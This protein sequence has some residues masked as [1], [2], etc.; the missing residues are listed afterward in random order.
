MHPLCNTGFGFF[1]DNPR[2]MLMFAIEMGGLE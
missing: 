1:G 2:R